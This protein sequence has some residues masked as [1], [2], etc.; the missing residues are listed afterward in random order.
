LKTILERN[1]I[2]IVKDISIKNMDKR[3]IMKNINKIFGVFLFTLFFSFGAYAEELSLIGFWEGVDHRGDRVGFLFQ[4]NGFLTIITQG[5]IIGGRDA[6]PEGSS[7][8]KY[9]I[10]TTENPYQIDLNMQKGERK[11]EIRLLAYLLDKNR[12]ILYGNNTNERP[13]KINFEDSKN[14]IILFKNY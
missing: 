2:L 9:S 12:I 13:E 6:D 10:K 14:L 4:E 8:V 1:L 11:D 3:L 7:S 5:K